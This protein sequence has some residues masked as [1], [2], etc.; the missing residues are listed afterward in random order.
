MFKC[1]TGVLCNTTGSKNINQYGRVF[2]NGRPL[3]DNL[4]IQILQMAI[5][6]V[7]PCEISRQLQVSHG[8]VSKILNRYFRDFTYTGVDELD[9]SA[10]EHS[11]VT[12]DVYGSGR[13]A[14]R[15]GSGGIENSRNLVFVCWKIYALMCP[16][17]S[18]LT[19]TMQCIIHN[20]LLRCSLCI[21][22]LHVMFT[23]LHILI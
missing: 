20:V 7:R 1:T 13:P 12:T 22:L 8:C 19:Q 23:R 16:N 5:D 15:V 4:R 14:D 6:G 3:P 10:D 17:L 9:Q 11:L 2:T 18:M 21:R